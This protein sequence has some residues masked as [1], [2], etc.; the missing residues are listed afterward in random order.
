MAVNGGLE[1]MRLLIV[2]DGNI[3]EIWL[4]GLLQ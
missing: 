1:A 4:H 2:D 3:V